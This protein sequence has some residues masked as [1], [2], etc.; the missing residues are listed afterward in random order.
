MKWWGT[1]VRSR[2]R[3]ATPCEVPISLFGK[4]PIAPDFLRRRCLGGA[5]AAFREW[6][7]AVEA[8]GDGVRAAWRLL[9]LAEGYPEA[10]LAQVAPSVD[11]T[12]TRRFPLALYASVPRRGLGSGAAEGVSNAVPAWCDLAEVARSLESAS[13]AEL[14]GILDGRQVRLD[15]GAAAETAAETAAEKVDLRDV[16]AA[17]GG[18]DAFAPRLWRL[19][20]V[21]ADLAGRRYRGPEIP[22]LSLPLSPRLSLE[23][24]AIAWLEVLD[25]HGVGGPDDAPLNVALPAPDVGE[26]SPRAVELRL[27]PRPLLH[28]DG[29]EWLSADP[30]ESRPASRVSF[31]GF[32]RFESRLDRLVSAGAPFEILSELLT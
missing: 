4:L 28:R 9:H 20:A 17:F 26:S 13:I 25:A 12:G 6:L 29:V 8:S 15:G 14:D 18:S 5:G 3:G 1:T 31:E 2:D 27:L 11:A 30:V 19:R 32:G 16:A 24:Q 21:L 23:A 10:V 7:S 22:C